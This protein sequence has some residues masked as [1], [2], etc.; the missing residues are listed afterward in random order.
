MRDARNKIRFERMTRTHCPKGHPYSGENLYV[1][2]HRGKGSRVCR[3]CTR[4][5]CKEWYHKTRSPKRF[6][7]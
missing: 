2:P 4:E 3:I 1:N 7:N 6:L 5:A